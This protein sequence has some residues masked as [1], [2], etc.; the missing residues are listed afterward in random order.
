MEQTLSSRGIIMS[1]ITGTPKELESMLGLNQAVLSTILRLAEK[2]GAARI[3]NTIKSDTGR[4]KPAN[5]W[6]LNKTIVIT[7]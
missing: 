4:G 3:V 5:V 6:E 1:T 7:L 2:N